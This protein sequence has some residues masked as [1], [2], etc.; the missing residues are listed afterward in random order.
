MGTTEETT[1]KSSR[2]LQDFPREEGWALQGKDGLDKRTPFAPG[3]SPI[4]HCDGE[5]MSQ[6]GWAKVPRYWVKH[7]SR[8]FCEGVCDEINIYTSGL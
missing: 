1:V 8:G 6:F 2:A 7:Y 5:F 3:I 4:S